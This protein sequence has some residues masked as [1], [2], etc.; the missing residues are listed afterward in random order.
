MPGFS[1]LRRG[2][3]IRARGRE[4]GTSIIS[5]DDYVGDAVRSVVFEGEIRT[6]IARFIRRGRCLPRLH[7]RGPIE[8]SLQLLATKTRWGGML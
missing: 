3:Q 7:H 6:G 5:T 4:K 8:D 1:F 2:F